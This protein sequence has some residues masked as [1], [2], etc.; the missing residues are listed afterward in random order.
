MSKCC[1]Y[2]LGLAI[3]VLLMWVS[4]LF[5]KYFAQSVPQ[6]NNAGVLAQFQE[7]LNEHK[8]WAYYEFGVTP[9]VDNTTLSNWIETAPMEKQIRKRFCSATF[10][11]GAS[12]TYTVQMLAGSISQYRVSIY[13]ADTPHGPNI[14]QCD[15]PRVLGQMQ[16]LF[17]S[18]KDWTYSNFGVVP[19]VDNT[20][21]S[22]VTELSVD[23][24]EPYKRYCQ[25][26]LPNGSIVSFSVKPTAMDGSQFQ[27]S[28][29]T[30]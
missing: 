25:A 21:L 30:R 2:F 7:I 13:P 1:K 22:S 20:T 6:C 28:A 8:D 14:P 11:N 3:I 27:V 24:Q 23:T 26:K 4:V 10:S 17:D 15:D 9:E 29:Y 18:Y 5:Y 12:V 16:V 19:G